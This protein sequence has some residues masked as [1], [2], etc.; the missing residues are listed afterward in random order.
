MSRF[1]DRLSVSP[2]T[3]HSGVPHVRY[4]SITTEES[5]T[6]ALLSTGTVLLETRLGDDDDDDDDAARC[7]CSLSSAPPAHSGHTVLRGWKCAA[8]AVRAWLSS[9]TSHLRGHLLTLEQTHSHRIFHK[10]VQFTWPGQITNHTAT[11]GY[12]L[13][14]LLNRLSVKINACFT[15][16]RGNVG[17]HYQ[18]SCMG[19][20]SLLS[21]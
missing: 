2:L 15:L 14:C 13:P 19:Q 20:A 16:S 9:A 17:L 10:E 18:Q 5:N 12:F 6:S 3:L 8:R 11:S 7:E 1:P 4:F 21:H